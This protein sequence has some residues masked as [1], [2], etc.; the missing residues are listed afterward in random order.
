MKNTI[1][2]FISLITLIKESIVF[3]SLIKFMYFLP[4]LILT[5]IPILYA[6]LNLTFH[7]FKKYYLPLSSDEYL[8][9][10][11]NSIFIMII[12]IYFFAPFVLRQLIYLFPYK[13]GNKYNIVLLGTLLVV[14][15]FLFINLNDIIHIN[16]M[17]ELN[18]CSLAFMSGFFELDDIAKFLA[19]LMVFTLLAFISYRFYNKKKAISE[20]DIL[21]LRTFTLTPDFYLLRLIVKSLKKGNLG[22]VLPPK[23]MLSEWDPYLIA[24]SGTFILPFKNLPL[25]FKENSDSWKNDIEEFIKNSHCIIID[26]TIMSEGTMWE[27]DTIRSLEAQSKTIIL[28]NKFHT[29]NLKEFH[30]ISNVII[31]DPMVS[32][33]STKTKKTKEALSK[34][35]ARIKTSKKFNS[36]IKKRKIKNMKNITKGFLVMFF[37]PLIYYIKYSLIPS[38]LEEAIIF[39]NKHMIK[40]FIDEGQESNKDRCGKP[41]LFIPLYNN[42]YEM[43]KFLLQNGLSPN[44]HDSTRGRLFKYSI[45]PLIYAI[46]EKDIKTIKL[47]LDYGANPTDE[48][49]M[50]TLFEGGTN[51]LIY[52]IRERDIEI[53]KLLLSYGADPNDKVH[54]KFLFDHEVSA[55]DV[56][57]DSN[58]SEIQLILLE[59]IKDN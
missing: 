57:I 48:V 51:P 55:M 27:I 42:N 47:L 17:Q 5:A 34:A 14:L 9:K 41:H 32:I 52:A 31:Y 7:Q 12:T 58:Q 56:A 20:L 35:F 21:Y 40:I 4:I 24:F 43:L 49:Q 36:T 38:D 26:I 46:K 16:L 59:Y 1:N 15:I 37:I 22:L 28:I 3:R 6:F 13:F 11:I 50:G 19:L 10:D 18:Y 33:F 2:N 53:I 39:K 44:R 45:N 30:D 23:S 25:L 29:Q 54:I 8:N